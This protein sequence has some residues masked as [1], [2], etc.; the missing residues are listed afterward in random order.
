MLIFPGA[1]LT[2]RPLL[3]NELFT[4]RQYFLRA[5]TLYL[6]WPKILCSK[7]ETAPVAMFT[8]VKAWEAQVKLSRT[9]GN[10]P[11]YIYFFN[12]ENFADTSPIY[13]TAAGIVCT[14][15]GNVAKKA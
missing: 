12:Y 2:Y 9:K 15:T 4:I 3:V 14:E 13:L 8:I 7:T 10:Y 1:N 11:I 6:T 5:V